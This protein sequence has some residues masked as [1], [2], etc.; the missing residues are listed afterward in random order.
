MADVPGTTRDWVGEIANIDGLPVML[1]DTPGVRSTEDAIERVA[2]EPQPS[3]GWKKADLVVLVLDATRPL[4][5]EQLP[6]LTEY[7]H[8]IRVANKCDGKWNWK[9]DDIV[10]IQT[11]A[12]TGAG[13]DKLRRAIASHFGCVDGALHG[14]KCWTD[15][16]RRLL[17]AAMREPDL[18]EDFI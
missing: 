4:E 8:A 3:R 7:P 9:V 15:R 12:T 2:I 1:I 17:E 13:I 14:A 6:L 16:Q 18:L 5:P 10:A 11:V